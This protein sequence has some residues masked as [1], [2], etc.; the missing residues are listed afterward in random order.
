M[1]CYYRGDLTA[2]E[3]HFTRGLDFFDDRDFRRAPNNLA[4]LAFAFAGLNA[5]ITGRADVARDRMARA[6]A[7]ANHSN[8]HDL[9]HSYFQ[10]ARLNF[11]L[12]EYGQGEVLAAQA[13]ALCL[14]HQFPNDEAMCRCAVG[15][16]E[17][18]LGRAEHGVPLIRQ[19][20][21]GMLAAGQRLS[22]G[23]NSACLADIEQNDNLPTALETVERAL[24]EYSEPNY[25]PE[26]LRIRGELRLK[27]GDLQLAEADFRD[28]VT[29]ARSMGAKAWELRAAMSLARL[30][31]SQGRRD[32]ACIMLGEIYSWFTEGFDTA[33]LKDA[34]ALLDELS[35]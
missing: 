6:M 25:R 14:K 31:A 19:G 11:L 13:L 16:M 22:V 20:I 29:M 3:H 23:L 1:V 28:S 15:Q 32:E 4:I 10:A 12:R 9:V 24:T 33:D 7:V 35:R 30:L 34:R 27:Q 2:A 8:P 18:R 17:A 26:T 5:W 21:A